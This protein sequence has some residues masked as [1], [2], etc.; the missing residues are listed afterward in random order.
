[1]KRLSLALGALVLATFC[2]QTSKADTFN[3]S[4]T[5]SL[6]NGSGII[7]ATEEGN[8][9]VYDIT[10]ITGTTNGQTITGLLGIG[11]FDNNDNK[12]YDPGNFFG[13]LDFDQHGVSYKIGTGNTASEV[14]L[15]EG[16][17]F[18]FLD[19]IAELNPPGKSDNQAELIDFEV[20]KIPSTSPVPEPG[21][22]ALLGT[23]ILGAAGAIRRRLMA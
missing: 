9:N 1:M 21:S 23:G 10:A 16:S 18:F 15:R 19:E 17:G 14:N 20:T 6:F 7:T 12:L 11:T 22:L 3:F 5:G 8:T 2:T 13:N 4:F